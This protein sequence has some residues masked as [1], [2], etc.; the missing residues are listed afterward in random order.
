M[1]KFFDNFYT[2][3]GF[4]PAIKSRLPTTEI[5]D[6]FENKLPSRLLEYWQEYG[7]CGWGEGS[8]WTV[9]PSEYEEVLKLW[10]KDTEFEKREGM[11]LINIML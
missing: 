10:I 11:G 7:F 5:L 2:F 8:F 1:N 9:N 4:G 3:S 6:N